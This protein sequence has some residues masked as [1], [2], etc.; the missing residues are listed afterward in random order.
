MGVVVVLKSVSW[1]EEEAP[2]E[3]EAEEPFT[4]TQFVPVPVTA[5]A[6]PAPSPFRALVVL[7][8][9]APG[10]GALP[11]IELVPQIPQCP[12]VGVLVDL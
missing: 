6:L 1:S 9:V 7:G 3:H 10:H 5:S 11:S 2:P 8:I 12:I 4:K